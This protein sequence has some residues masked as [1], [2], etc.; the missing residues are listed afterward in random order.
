MSSPTT[1]RLSRVIAT[2]ANSVLAIGDTTA[3][4]YD[5]SKWVNVSKQVLDN[6]CQGCQLPQQSSFQIGA[7]VAGPR[8]IYVGTAFGG[9]IKRG[10][11][12]GWDQALGFEDGQFQNAGRITGV[13]GAPGGCGIAVADGS[14][15]YGPILFRGVGPTGCNSSP[16]TPPSSWP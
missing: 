1:G 2:G 7:W 16:F 6:G 9:N 3:L 5:G 12:F 4:Q 14:G 13:A 15:L 11:L 10:P 8:E